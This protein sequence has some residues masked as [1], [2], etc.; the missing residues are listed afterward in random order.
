MAFEVRY[1]NLF[2]FFF[3]LGF[4][5]CL[6]CFGPDI[7]EKLKSTQAGGDV[8]TTTTTLVPAPTIVLP[9]A[10]YHT[11]SNLIRFR[12]DD[13]PQID[14]TEVEVKQG[15]T[16]IYSANA[17]T[18]ISTVTL[19]VG[20]LGALTM[21]ARNKKSGVWSNYSATVNFTIDDYAT[22]TALLTRAYN[23][24]SGCGDTTEP[25]GVR[26]F[27]GCGDS[28]WPGLCTG[29][30]GGG[31][32]V[33]TCN[34]GDYLGTNV[35]GAGLYSANSAIFNA[36]NAPDGS[37]TATGYLQNALGSDDAMGISC[38]EK[39]DG[40]NN[41][42]ALWLYPN[43]NPATSDNLVIVRHYP[44]NSNITLT[45]GRFAVMQNKGAGSGNAVTLRFDCI[46]SHLTA[47]YKSGADFIPLL[48]ASDTSWAHS[49]TA[50][51][52][53]VGVGPGGIV[54]RHTRITAIEI[55]KF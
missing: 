3:A 30:T 25:F 5:F 39:Q 45:S 40:A 44:D 48:S 14:T 43:R 46:G 22:A 31:G 28:P 24:E 34:A 10:G 12:S 53:A 50:S 52:F 29:V 42:Y 8:A 9:P 18:G 2:P 32:N 38:R 26:F 41:H 6:R 20:T 55:R 51:Y 36:Y 49:L 19:P 23:T 17:A 33:W 37:V 21:R 1:R 27:F 11:T 4:F 7:G 13:N 35:S 15:S 54:N 47:Y 16:V